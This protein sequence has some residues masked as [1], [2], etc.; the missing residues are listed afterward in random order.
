MVCIKLNRP[1]YYSFY[2]P[3]NIDLH[4]QNVTSAT[5]P[6]RKFRH[7]NVLIVKRKQLTKQ[8]ETFKAS[9]Q[10]SYLHVLPYSRQMVEDAL[11]FHESKPQSAQAA[12]CPGFR[13]EEDLLFVRIVSS[14]LGG[15][16]FAEFATINTSTLFS[17]CKDTVQYSV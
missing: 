9:K 4:G 7:G 10:S 8:T 11:L 2:G 6:C 13:R 15:N 3:F 14:E 5:T 17:D 1:N 16:C 12:P